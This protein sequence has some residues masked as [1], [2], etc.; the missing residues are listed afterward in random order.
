MLFVNIQKQLPIFTIQFKASFKSEITVILGSSGSGKTT[1]LNCIAGLKHPD[2]GMIKWNEKHLFSVDKKLVPPQQRKI[3]Y[4]FQDYAL[5]PHMTVQQNIYYALKKEAEKEA[6]SPLIKKL[7]V[8]YLMDK[9]PHEISGGE[10]QRVALA[11]ALSIKPN[12]LLLDEPFSAL[13]DQT[14]TM[15]QKILLEL[16]KE[17]DIPVIM[18]THHQQEAKILGDRMIHIHDGKIIKDEVPIFN[19]EATV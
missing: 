9:Y 3:G 18:V 10:Q 14:R 5:F 17:W 12:V 19:Q 1:I 11:R 8:A 2:T 16:Y 15:C 13:D 4:L 6:T 7:K